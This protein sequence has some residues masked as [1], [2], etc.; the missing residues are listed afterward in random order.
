MAVAAAVSCAY[1]LM[2][3]TKVKLMGKSGLSRGRNEKNPFFLF[4]KRRVERER[5]Q[6]KKIDKTL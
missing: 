1:M 2:L 6:R 3:C 5:K 4:T